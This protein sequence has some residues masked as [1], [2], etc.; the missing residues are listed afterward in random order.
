[1][2][3]LYHGN[4]SVCSAKARVALVEKGLTWES[5]LLNLGKDEHMRPDYL[6]L[7][8]DAV[9]PTLVHN[10]LVV[11]ESSVIIEYVDTLSDNNPLMPKDKAAEYLTRLWLIRAIA[12]HEAIN[13]LTFATYMRER[14]AKGRT[15][16]EIDAQ[17]ARLRNPQVAAKRRDLFRNGA[18][19]VFVD[20]AL[21]VMNQVFTDMQAALEKSAWLA[22]D[23]YSLADVTLIAY[24]DRLDRLAMKGL[25]AGRF[26]LVDPWLR[27][28]QARPSYEAA[29]ARYI[30]AGDYGEAMRAAGGAAWPAIARRL[31]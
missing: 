13:T 30:P 27:A 25:W 7:N 5:A 24:L 16:Q 1:M 10:G 17:L 26:P 28:V 4:T 11:R 3:T 18:D 22:G 2:L 21:T 31:A 12:I 8:P 23:T 20:G 19:S 9:V 6:R 15:Q 29:V 14:E